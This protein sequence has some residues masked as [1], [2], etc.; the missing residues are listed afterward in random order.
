ML[1]RE[2]SL[3]PGTVRRDVLRVTFSQA[4]DGALHLFDPAE[5]GR[6]HGPRAV[7]CVRARA[8]PVPGDGLGV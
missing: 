6:A 8:V 5:R 2:P 1:T 3:V 7:V 4:S